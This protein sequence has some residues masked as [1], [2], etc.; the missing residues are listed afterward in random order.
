L[1]L[2]VWNSQ[3]IIKHPLINSAS[4]K[5]EKEQEETFLFLAFED[6]SK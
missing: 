5:D 4:K 6:A 3:R 2:T 1:K